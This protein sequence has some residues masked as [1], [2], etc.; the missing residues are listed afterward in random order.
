MPSLI[1]SYTP[2]I[3]RLGGY[4]HLFG[5]PPSQLVYILLIGN[6][7]RLRTPTLLGP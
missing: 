7:A 3:P 4:L 6:I 1:N 2:P 5:E